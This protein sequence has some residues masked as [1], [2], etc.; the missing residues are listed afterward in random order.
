MRITPIS[1]HYYFPGSAIRGRRG[2]PAHPHQRRDTLP[3]GR[4]QRRKAR[5]LDI[6]VQ[7]LL[8]LHQ[9]DDQ[10]THPNGR[11]SGA[12]CES[13]SKKGPDSTGRVR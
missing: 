2:P 10:R 11:I 4:Q 8:L 6:H 7:R 13:L 9:R 1:T 5:A 12:P 3:Q